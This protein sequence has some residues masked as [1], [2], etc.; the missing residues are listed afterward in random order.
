MK[1][2]FYKFCFLLLFAFA[3]ANLQAEIVN[4][5][6]I[7]GNERIAKETILVYGEIKKNKDYSQED[8]NNLIKTLY[9][10]NF[11]SFSNQ[12]KILVVL[13]IKKFFYLQYYITMHQ[14]N[15]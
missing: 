12:G 8:I 1:R 6:E 11:F 7:Y 14:F 5:V 3:S 4:K 2:I 9:Q 10:T 15:F 13:F